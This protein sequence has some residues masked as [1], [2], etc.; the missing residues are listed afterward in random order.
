MSI[1]NEPKTPIFT[2]IGPR[3]PKQITALSPG[4]M[5]KLA[6]ELHAM[7]LAARARFEHLQT[8]LRALQPDFAG[9][10]FFK[11]AMDDMNKIHM[12]EI[13]PAELFEGTKAVKRPISQT[14]TSSRVS[15]PSSPS[16]RV[17]R[18]EVRV[19]KP[20]PEETARK[21]T[22]EQPVWEYEEALDD[23]DG[24]D[25]RKL[26][27]AGFWKKLDALVAYPDPN[28]YTALEDTPLPP[29]IPARLAKVRP[30]S[31]QLNPANGNRKVD[32]GT[33]SNL[34]GGL[35]RFKKEISDVD[36]KLQAKAIVLGHS[37]SQRMFSLLIEDSEGIM[38]RRM[39]QSAHYT[40]ATDGETDAAAG[41]KKELHAGVTLDDRIRAELEHL[42]LPFPLPAKEELQNT[43]DDD[44]CWELR[45]RT[46]QLHQQVLNNNKIRKR[47][48]PLVAQLSTKDR[49]PCV[50]FVSLCYL[51]L[52]AI[53]FCVILCV[54]S[55]YALCFLM[56]CVILCFVS[57][58]ALC[59]PMLCVILCLVS[60]YALCYLILCYPMLCVILCFVLSYVLCILCFVLS[61]ALCHLMLCVILCFVLSY[62]L[63]YPMLC[64]ILF[65]VILCSVLSYALCYPMLCVILCFVLSYALCYLML[66]VILCSVSSYALCYLILCHLTLCFISYALCYLI[67]CYL[68]LCYILCFVLSYALCY[69]ML[70]VILC[71]V[72]SYAL[73]YLALCVILCFVSSYALCYLILCVIL[74][75][76][77]SYALCYLM[78][79]VILCFVSYYALCYPM[80]CVILRFVLS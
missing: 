40:L 66:C 6:K 24:A 19:E 45:V 26:T 14:R 80:L 50:R 56:L 71:F 69:P 16:K 42:K 52:C 55:S 22:S 61:Y 15:E 28:T 43:R 18:E 11:H 2:R 46:Q 1:N 48:R 20:P 54:V 67:F 41:N 47:L 34:S 58:Y 73:C 31:P 29:P 72:L 35:L 4:D 17:S 59:Y 8:E 75:L 33:T 62:A 70:C 57:S 27:P 3:G 38:K 36:A 49:V 5:R 44:V 63:C 65:C 9:R 37:L 77:L 25:L 7:H 74:C 76:V 21:G 78:L 53:L 30:N 39:G 23:G 13:F 79:C 60:S 51:M 64:V 32:K 10:T 12:P 68:I